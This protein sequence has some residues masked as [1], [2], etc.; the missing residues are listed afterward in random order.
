MKTRQR[1]QFA[2]DT[3]DSTPA[4]TRTVTTPLV[5][6]SIA[7]APT[8]N[9]IQVA[10]SQRRFDPP[11]TSRRAARAEQTS[12]P[13]GGRAARRRPPP[14]SRRRSL[15]C[16]PRPARPRKAQEQRKGRRES[17]EKRP[18]RAEKVQKIDEAARKPSHKCRRVLRHRFPESFLKKPVPRSCVRRDSRGVGFGENRFIEPPCGRNGGIEQFGAVRRNQDSELPLLPP[19]PRRED[20]QK[21]RESRDC[22]ERTAAES[23]AMNDSRRSG[24]QCQ[25]RAEEREGAA[26]ISQTE[27]RPSRSEP[28]QPVGAQSTRGKDQPESDKGISDRLG[29]RQREQR[30][31]TPNSPQTRPASS[32]ARPPATC[33]TSH[34]AAVAASAPKRTFR[35][36]AHASETPEKA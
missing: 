26:Q 35:I 16:A 7:A 10:T 22:T 31:R 8:N 14:P 20:E 30:H 2:C 29:H 25:R 17:P 3:I 12:I 1:D 32:P 15:P 5:R 9:P 27:Q 24:E 6:V 19:H 4:Q 28:W 18:L 36:I 21:P 33:R 13:A 23:A 11:T 34:P